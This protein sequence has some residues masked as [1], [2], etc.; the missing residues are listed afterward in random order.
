MNMSKTEV[1]LSPHTPFF[2]ILVNDNSQC[3]TME[4]PKP[5]E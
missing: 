2:P 4:K 5:S 1:M 3:S